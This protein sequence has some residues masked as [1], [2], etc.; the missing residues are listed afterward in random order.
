MSG[1]MMAKLYSSKKPRRM[2]CRDTLRW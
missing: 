1:K 2:K